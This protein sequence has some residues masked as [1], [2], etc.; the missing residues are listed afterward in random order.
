MRRQ[1]IVREGRQFGRY[2]AVGLLNTTFGYG[3]YALLIFIGLHYAW[4]SL[5]ATVWGV[6]FNF[7]T[8]GRIV[9]RNSDNNRL[10]KFFLVYG[11]VY[12]L[13]LAGLAFLD[14][15]RV[16]LYLAGLV[17]VPP[18]AIIAYMLNR[19]FVFGGEK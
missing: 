6:L 7:F 16:D 12:I 15:L 17:M 9:F 1:T 13:N 3:S 10:F 14:S 8:T 19:R 4:A 5:I 18:A 2:I 11:V